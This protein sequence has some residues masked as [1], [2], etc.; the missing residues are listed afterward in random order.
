MS[1]EQHINKPFI[2]MVCTV[3]TITDYSGVHNCN[4]LL[5]TLRVLTSLHGTSRI[6]VLRELFDS[7]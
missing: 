4:V 2:M 6:L 5:S 7:I 3:L 1:K